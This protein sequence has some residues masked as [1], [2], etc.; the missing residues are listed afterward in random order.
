MDACL[1]IRPRLGRMPTRDPKAA[2]VRMLLPVSEPKDMSPK[3]AAMAAAEPPLEPPVERSRS[4]ALRTVPNA[5][6][7]LVPQTG[8]HEHTENEQVHMK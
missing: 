1:L 7:T 4:Y 5:A 2:G 3:L 6:G 8:K